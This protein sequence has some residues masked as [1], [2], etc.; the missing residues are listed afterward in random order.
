[1]ARHPDSAVQP[2][3]EGDPKEGLESFPRAD[4]SVLETAQPKLIDASLRGPVVLTRHGR[5]AFV[6]LPVDQF[7]RLALLAEAR[8]L[9]GPTVIEPG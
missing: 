9:P 3:R 6:I 8:R 2:T 4:L 1:M 5:D 7:Q